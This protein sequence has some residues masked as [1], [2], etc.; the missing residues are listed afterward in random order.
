MRRTLEIEAGMRR[1][2]SMPGP[3]PE[4]ALGTQDAGLDLES[5]WNLPWETTRPISGSPNSGLRSVNFELRSVAAAAKS[6][7]DRPRTTGS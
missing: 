4:A 2:R 7:I 6:A 3:R 1:G 5:R